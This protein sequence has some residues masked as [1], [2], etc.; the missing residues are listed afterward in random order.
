MDSSYKDFETKIDCR[1]KEVDLVSVGDK[2]FIERGVPYPCYDEYVAK[3]AISKGKFT[4]IE[5]LE[6]NNEINFIE[7]E[8]IAFGRGFERSEADCYVVDEIAKCRCEEPI[9]RNQTEIEDNIGGL[10]Y[11]IYDLGKEKTGFIFMDIDCSCDT[12]IIVSFDEVLTDDDVSATRY[13]IANG[14]VWFL[15]SGSYT[16]IANE[17]HSLRYVKI[18]N[19]SKGKVCVKTLGIKEFALDY[20]T[21]ELGSD[22][23]RLNDIYMAAVETFRQNTLDIYMDCPSRER[24][25]WLCDSY[26][27]AKVERHL[28]GK[29]VVERNFLENFIFSDGIEDIPSHM[30]PMCYPAD[31]DYGHYIP[32]W[33]MWYVIQLEEYFERTKDIELVNNA[34]DKIFL[35]SFISHLPF[36][37]KN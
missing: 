14:I 32:N 29:S 1:F 10:E 27:T 15:K 33:A 3:G 28:T 5:K 7:K 6:E 34:K 4:Y 26:F 36:N 12:E 9:L 17:S 20:K 21:K 25:G 37:F 31:S 24:A 11:V 16:L 22:N 13:G 8:D 35:V 18:A 23:Q 2:N 30:F 19:N